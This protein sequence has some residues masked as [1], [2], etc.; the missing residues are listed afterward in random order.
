MRIRLLI[1]AAAALTLTAC[2]N[3]KKDPNLVELTASAERQNDQLLQHERMLAEQRQKDD[4]ECMQAKSE[5]AMAICFLGKTSTTLANHRAGTGAG[6]HQPVLPQYSPPPT[7]LQQ[8][9]Q[10]AQNVGPMVNGVISGVVSF[11]AT[12]QAN[13]TTR[14]VSSQNTQRETATVQA[15]A[16][17]STTLANAP[18]AI[19][20]GAGGVYSHGAVTQ[21]T[22]ST[23]IA[24]SNDATLGV[25]QGNNAVNGDENAVRHNSTDIINS[26]NCV[27]G[28][29]GS[30]A[31]GAPGG[32]GGP[33]GGGGAS[34]GANGGMA[35]G[36]ATGG[37]G[38]LGGTGGSGG[39]GG[40]CT[41]VVLPPVRPTPPA[42]P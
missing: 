21:L 27:A 31:P 15:F 18:P 30:G 7:A 29:G 34:S 11:D 6:P 5:G 16:N 35:G 41:P 3:I 22:E 39:A 13:E 42:N 19:Q 32:T 17:V 2:F 20:V 10:F 37:A 28:S 8:I 33:G 24:N 40:N 9:G 4:A 36:G 14:W 26:G 38:G 23:L 25:R 1:I 12:R